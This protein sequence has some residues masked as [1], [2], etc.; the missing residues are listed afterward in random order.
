MLWALVV[1]WGIGVG[2][3]VTQEPLSAAGVLA[4]FGGAL[5][6]TGAMVVVWRRRKAGGSV[7]AQQLAVGSRRSQSAQKAA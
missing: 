4:W 3:R 7:T 2:I 5:V 6:L 1:L